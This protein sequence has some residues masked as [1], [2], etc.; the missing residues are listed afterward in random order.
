MSLA[1]TASVYL[2]EQDTGIADTVRNLCA[3][4][5]LTLKRFKSTKD[6]LVAMTA[7]ASP[8]CVIAA[9]D[10]PTGQALEILEKLEIQKPEVPVIILGHHS[11]IASAVAV[12]KAGAIDYIEKPRIYGRLA[13]HLNQFIK[14]CTSLNLMPNRQKKHLQ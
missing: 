3:E 5:S 13:E 6:L 10:Q 12:I 7:T 2:L 9:N 4:K 1:T 8:A 14:R 11:D